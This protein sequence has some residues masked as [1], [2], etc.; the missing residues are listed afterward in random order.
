MPVEHTLP[1]ARRTRRKNVAQNV[2]Q[3]DAHRTG[4]GT[5]LG[6]R[7]VE[8]SLGHFSS[9][10]QAPSA[11]FG[12]NWPSFD[13][14]WPNSGKCWPKSAEVDPELGQICQKLAN[15]GRLWRPASRN[16]VEKCPHQL[17]V[18]PFSGFRL[19]PRP[20]CINLAS[21]FPAFFRH[22]RRAAGSI[23]SATVHH[24]RCC[25]LVGG[26]GMGPLCWELAHV[27]RLGTTPTL[28]ETTP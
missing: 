18:E 12:Q 3:I 4:R 8:S 15:F 9:E 16:S 7:L 11:K 13:Q 10:F 14:I 27:L 2:R 1:A 24:G 21:M 28:A 17:F 19:A 23:C 5:E 25:F 26:R 6:K 20:W 22:V